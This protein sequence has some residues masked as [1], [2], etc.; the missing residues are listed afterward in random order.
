MKKEIKKEKKSFWKSKLFLFAILPLFVVMVT[1][2]VLTYYA[3]FSATFTVSSAI[4]VSGVLEQPL[5]EV[6]SE[7]TIVGTPITITNDATSLREITLSDDSPSEIETSY[8]SELT[9]SQKVVDFNLDVWELTGDKA[10]V[11][12]TVVGNVLIAEVTSGIKPDYS[13][14]YY[15]D[16]SDRFNSPAKAIKLNEIV[17][18]LP[19]E[20]DANAEEY[21]YC[22][23]GEYETCHGAKLW[24]VPDTAI[25]SLGNVDWSQ[26]SN[27]LFETEL[28]QYNAGGTIVI[29]P[30]SSLVLTP[31]YTI[32]P[33]V[34]GTYTITTTIA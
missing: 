9:L 26:A 20:N 29:Y 14:I 27:F 8:V 32:A 15:K 10:V 7:D 16:N 28:V 22:L 31:V 17:G 21:N 13:L 12:Y 25:D 33:Y 3:V 19:Y 5:G 1:A 30:K 23:T 18:N 4:I 24:Y 2:G 11:R 34:T 6:L